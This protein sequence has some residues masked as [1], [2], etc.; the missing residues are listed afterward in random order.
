MWFQESEM[1]VRINKNSEIT[2]LLGYE[3]HHPVLSARPFCFLL[4]PPR[5]KNYKVVRPDRDR[6]TDRN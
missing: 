4:G 5:W 3:K 1:L 6:F 2:F